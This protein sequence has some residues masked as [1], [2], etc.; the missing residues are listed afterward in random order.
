MR[1]I[2]P[3]YA[4]YKYAKSP[5]F[6][7]RT[8]DSNLKVTQA[9]KSINGSAKSKK[10][11][12]WTQVDVEAVARK[13]G[14]DRSVIVRTLQDWH[15][16][17]AIELQPSGVINRFR[18]LQRLPDNDADKEAVVAALCK[19][20]EASE[21]DNMARVYDVIGLITAKACLTRGLARHFGD[22]S[23]VPI[24][25]CA[26]CSYCITGRG[27]SFD[28][29]INRSRKGRINEAK[30]K[31]ILK[32]TKIRDDPRLLARVAFG[33]TSPRITVEKLSKHAVF[34][35]M[36]DCDFDVCFFPPIRFPSLQSS[37]GAC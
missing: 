9:L 20:F 2:T 29:S 19:Y 15:D 12:K 16:A 11:L 3:K 30:F 26:H 27:V 1:A 21:R 25:G 17:D 18:I 4:H 23:S 36:D 35:S 37:A 32:A 13:A 34:G 7:S 8:G 10:P 22:E 33:I 5:A 24:E 28:H 6:E 14:V 31:A